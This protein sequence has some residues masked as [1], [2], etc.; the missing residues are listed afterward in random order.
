MYIELDM[1]R[2]VCMDNIDV[3]WYIYV[4][5]HIHN[6]SSM[7]HRNGMPHWHM[8]VF[9]WDFIR[10]NSEFVQNGELNRPIKRLVINRTR[11]RSKNQN[12]MNYAFWLGF[13][14]PSMGFL[15]SKNFGIYQ[16][17]GIC[18]CAHGAICLVFGESSTT[19]QA[20]QH[21]TICLQKYPLVN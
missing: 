4:Y 18:G 21:W 11:T 13:Q 9:G 2:Y 8:S 17:R 14:P 6:M 10:L 12:R 3:L 1:Y 5:I 20:F 15:N 7:I 19:W 16:R